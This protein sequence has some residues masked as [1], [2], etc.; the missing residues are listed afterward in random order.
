[1]K[2]FFFTLFV[3]L[4]IGTNSYPQDFWQ[5]QNFGNGSKV[6][7]M[8]VKNNGWVYAGCNDAIFRSTDIG[9]TWEKV[10]QG[11]ADINCMAYRS[12]LGIFVG[13]SN[14]GVLK[15]L[16]DAS[17]NAIGLSGKNITDIVI[18]SSG[19]VFVSCSSSNP[20]GGGIYKTIDDGQSWIESFSKG[21]DVACLSLD[22]NNNIFAGSYQGDIL[23][24]TDGGSNWV[25][26]GLSA[27][28]NSIRG[29]CVDL[30]G[31]I[32]ALQNGQLY[33][34]TDNGGNWKGGILTSL[35]YYNK[36]PFVV[37]SN[38]FL[39]LG[40]DGEGAFMSTDFGEHWNSINS[41]LA[42]SNF[43]SLAIDD[44]GYLYAGTNT[45]IHRSSNPIDPTI[46]DVNEI[47]NFTKKQFELIQ[48]FPNPFNPN[49]I[50]SYIIP[51][52]C[53]V[54][55][56]VY[57][58]QGKEITT[59]VN[60]EKVAGNYYIQF[61]ASYLSSGIYFYQLRTSDYAETKKMLLMK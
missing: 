20:N 4:F 3:I 50:I 13:L 27:N 44:G 21:T 9:K 54:Q 17:W 55:I 14:G 37:S 15:S 61:N 58:I 56:K 49:S 40:T 7:A 2:K 46:V 36:F 33:K 42:N 51:R 60:E 23:K 43:Y 5:K 30:L 16:S 47:D 22:K 26:I 32:F 38:N 25:R 19:N 41:G 34:S 39:F 48:N 12:G 31:N 29:I 10:Y 8:V 28:T 11:S 6:Y 53:F 24:S 57:D 1:M 35:D 45:M 18:N 59:L 52:T